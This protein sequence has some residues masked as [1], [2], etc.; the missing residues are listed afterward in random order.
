MTGGRT[1]AQEALFHGFSLGRHVPA[2]HP[3]RSIHLARWE[4][5]CSAVSLDEISSLLCDH[6]DWQIRVS[7]WQ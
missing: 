5:S 7:A 6:D 4:S 1:A 2:D 3:P